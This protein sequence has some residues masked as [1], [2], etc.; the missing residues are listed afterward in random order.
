MIDLLRGKTVP[1]TLDI[2]VDE[3]GNGT[4]TV[5]LDLA[6]LNEGRS[7]S[8]GKFVSDPFDTQITYVGN[9][10]TFMMGGTNGM[11][12]SLT[13]NVIG[14]SGDWYIDGVFAADGPGYSIKATWRVTR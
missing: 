12:T 2:T 13:G 7:E 5:L 9:T 14:Q 11:S 10:I 3:S 6:S 1:M 8:E 4:A